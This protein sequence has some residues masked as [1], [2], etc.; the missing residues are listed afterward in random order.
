MMHQWSTQD[1]LLHFHQT[2]VAYHLVLTAISLQSGN[3]NHKCGTVY[4]G[5]GHNVHQ[6]SMLNKFQV[7]VVL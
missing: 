6:C 3:S 5:K 1:D 2:L 4:T 7:Q